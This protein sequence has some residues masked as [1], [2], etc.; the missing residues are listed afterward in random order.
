MLA[1]LLEEL[2][3][4][5]EQ[6]YMTCDDDGYLIPAIPPKRLTDPEH[7]FAELSG[8][9]FYLTEKQIMKYFKYLNDGRIC[10]INGCS[11]SLEDDSVNI[12]CNYC[13]SETMNGNYFY[14]VTCDKNMCSYCQNIEDVENTSYYAKRMDYYESLA[15]KIVPCLKEHKIIPVDDP[16]QICTIC[17]KAGENDLKNSLIMSKTLFINKEK[18]VKLCEKCASAH[19]EQAVGL[20]QI[21][22][23]LITD[24]A[25]F[26]S[27]LDWIPLI[28]NESYGD[29]VL[30]NLNPDS[31]YYK[32][33]AFCPID[34]HGRCGYHIIKDAIT[35]E[36]I[37]ETINKCHSLITDKRESETIEEEETRYYNT[38]P[39][40]KLMNERNMETNFG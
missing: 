4:P 40:K 1:T 19:P 12:E 15:K 20:T 11:I 8:G 6:T 18:T 13:G 9:H 38:V 17:D 7:K 23:V 35:F 16:K 22:N 27:I 36:E 29:L 24:F 21:E 2:N 39:L 5:K 31:K 10:K 32:R 30:E 14:C 3:F 28:E 26:G 25:G 34:G 33:L 37:V